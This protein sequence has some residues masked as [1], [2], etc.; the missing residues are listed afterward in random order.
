M[1]KKEK[2]EAKEAM[3]LQDDLMSESE[4]QLDEDFD[5]QRQKGGF[6]PSQDD[7]DNVFAYKKMRMIPE[8][9]AEFE[10]LIDKDVVLANVKT[11]LPDPEQM[12][13]MAETISI[14]K[15]VFVT[16]KTV[17]LVDGSGKP[18]PKYFDGRIVGYEMEE[19]FVF[20]SNFQPVLEFLHAG[21][22]YDHVASRAM[23]DERESVLDR[24]MKL[25]KGVKRTE[26]MKRG[27]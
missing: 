25:E 14:F 20:D 6:Y 11:K 18:V 26:E 7:P 22:K 2:K 12:R 19:V 4:K 13:F 15:R 10:G 23:G 1:D 24:T 9:N 3:R 17:I 21:F 16:P 27:S 8:S 5:R